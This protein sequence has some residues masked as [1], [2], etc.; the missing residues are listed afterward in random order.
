MTTRLE[1]YHWGTLANRHQLGD[2][3]H[4][5]NLVLS[6]TGGPCGIVLIMPAYSAS[7]AMVGKQTWATD[8]PHHWHTRSQKIIN[9]WLRATTYKYPVSRTAS[10]H[11]FPDEHPPPSVSV[12]LRDNY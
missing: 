4:S 10:R 11:P 7:C 8:I 9:L 12:R 6:R 2:P 1:L 5:F 3:S